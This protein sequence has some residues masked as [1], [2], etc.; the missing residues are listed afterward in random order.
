MTT[1]FHSTLIFGLVRRSLGHDPARPELITSMDDRHCLGEPGEEQR[2]LHGRVTTADDDD[3]LVAEE[4]AVAG[5]ARRDTVAEKLLLAGHAQAPPGRA[6][7]QQD[8][9]RPV[10][11]LAHPDGLDVTGQVDRGWR[12]R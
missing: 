11:R 3:V 2:L 4:E 12:R 7:G 6:G 8:G 10:R 9:L 5:G 1:V